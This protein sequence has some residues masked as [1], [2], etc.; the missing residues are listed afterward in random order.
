MYARSTTLTGTPMTVDDGISYVVDEV[1]PAVTSMPGNVG[2]SML[3]D[4]ET[5]RCIVTSSWHDREAMA[6][7]E[8]GVKGLR[9]RAGGIFG[10]PPEVQEWEVAVMHRRSEAPSGAATRVTWSRADP[11]DVDR[12]LDAYR[13]IMVPRME[14]YTGF[15]SVS[16]FLDREKGLASSAV[17]F[18]DRECMAASRTHARASRDDFARLMRMEITDHDEFDLILAHLRIPE[19]V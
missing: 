3:A 17:T 19:T 4:R 18:E 14:G 16:L 8:D 12:I 2:L 5:G 7:S 15:C 9:E 6:A 13:T 10:G 1:M 11:A